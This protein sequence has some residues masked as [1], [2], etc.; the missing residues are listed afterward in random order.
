MTTTRSSLR[1]LAPAAEPGPDAVGTAR[2]IVIERVEPELDGGRYPAKRVVGDWLT[3]SADIIVDGHDQLGAALLIRA[4][5]ELEWREVRMR[6]GRYDR[7]SGRVRLTRNR[8]HVYTVEAWR[9]QVASWSDRLV[10][11]ARARIAIA[12]ELAE[13][14]RLLE[15]TA[16]RAAAAGAA[17][18]AAV[19]RDARTRLVAAPD[20]RT[21]AR[22]ARER[23][24]LAAGGRHPDRSTATRYDRE[25][26]LVVDRPAAVTGAWYELFPRSQG[27]VKGNATTLVEAEWRLPDLARLGF[28][29]VYLPPIHPIG[30]T[31]RKGRN[32][33]VKA[34]PDEVGSP[35]A[36]GSAAGGH[37]AVASELGG[38]EAFHHFRRAAERLGLEV[39]L[40]LAIQASPD[41]PWVREHPDW[42]R[43]APNGTIRHAE[44]P[45]KLYQDVYP[46]DF[47]TPDL[48][49]RVALWEAWRQVILTWVARGVRIF[50]VD[51][52]HTKPVAFWAWLIRTVQSHHPDVIFLSEAFTR[53][54]PMRLLSKAGFTQSYTYFTW[55]TTRDALRDYLIELTRTE[56][57]Q[58]YRGNLFTN[59]PDINPRYLARGRAMFVS[60]FVLASTL[61]GLYG[62]YSGFELLEHRR[63]GRTEEYADSEK[64]EIKV[65]DW[66]APGNLKPLIAAINR[67]RREWPALRRTETLR[68]EKVRGERTVFY[69]RAL[70]V[71]RIDLLSEDPKQW[72]RP[73][74][75]AVNV[76]PTRAERA[77]L[78]PN[79]KAVGIDP[80]RPYRYT[81]L[82]TGASRLRRGR[83]LPLVLSPARPFVIFTLSQ[84]P[85]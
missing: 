26:E 18:D 75:V 4:D 68:F 48:E 24:L 47:H 25:L 73:I 54:K 9:D 51:N 42:F 29:V 79:L 41:H 74:W 21:A 70:P 19:L 56:M 27:R 37:D 43:R 67:L 32:N 13:G 82:M 65:R 84:D 45:P 62:I 20:D 63:I 23:I 14:H 33:A 85:A 38:P 55:R 83:E 22:I 36:V 8:W 59:T 34:Q 64:Y 46:F 44:N 49:S 39:A 11:K 35:W 78:R 60:R 6:A 10:R 76:T 53:H 77:V 72:R 12:T 31:N 17:A 15:R 50:R 57:R 61:S 5:D 69:R 3:V 2:T 40:D 7:W 52:P 81:D 30:T 16:R 28:D 58:Y 1:R 71:G 80:T 66:D